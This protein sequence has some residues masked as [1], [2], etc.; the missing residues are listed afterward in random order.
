MPANCTWKREISCKA[1]Q[2]S[3]SCVGLAMWHPV[4]LRCFLHSAFCGEF[5]EQKD[6]TSEPFLSCM[7]VLKYT[8]VL[9]LM[10]KRCSHV[11]LWF[12]SACGVHRSR[13]RPRERTRAHLVCVHAQRLL[14]PEPRHHQHSTSIY[15]WNTK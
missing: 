13:R 4:A 5:L 15:F 10:S 11:S 7:F 14:S 1:R 9:S 12:T 6:Q 2:P 3:I 8:R